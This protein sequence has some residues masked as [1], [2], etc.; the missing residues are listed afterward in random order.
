[1][2]IVTD[3]GMDLTPEQLEGLDIHYVPLT[4][5]LNGK[6]YRSGEDIQ[7]EEFYH[8]LN[9]TP[10]FPTTSQPS[11]GDFADGDTDVHARIAGL[12]ASDRDGQAP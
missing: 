2:Q 11:A 3:R 12:W 6:T 9:A 1:M 5:T 10:S 8:L 7:P 4:L